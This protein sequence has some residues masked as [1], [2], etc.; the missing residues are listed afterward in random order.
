MVESTYQQSFAGSADDASDE[1]A[2]VHDDEL[3]V[4]EPPVESGAAA[5]RFSAVT[6]TRR[7][8]A[9]PV[10]AKAGDVLAGKYLVEQA[11]G[12]SGQELVLFARH[13]ELDQRVRV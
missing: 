5:P 10:T 8:S 13:L 1:D 11:V 2:L 6:R 9:R 7:S 4:G 3:L 12:R